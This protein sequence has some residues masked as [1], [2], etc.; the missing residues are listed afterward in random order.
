MSEKLDWLVAR[1]KAGKM[2]RRE[3]IG[4]TTAMGVSAALASAL[5]TKAA[6]AEPKK[7]GVI[8]AGLTGGES[9]NT[10][11]PALAASVMPQVA[12]AHWGEQL[13][14]LNPDG[15]VDFRIGEEVSSSADSKTWTF[16]IRQGVTFSNGQA[17]TAED[18]MATLKRHTDEASQSGALGVVKDISE[19]KA[20]GD[21]LTLTLANASADLPYLLT[22]YHLV[23]QPGGGIDNP[24]AG[25]GAG[26]YVLETFE[27][28][29]RY[30]MQKNPNYWDDRIGHADTIEILS[31]N[32]N[33]AR[34]AALQSGQV[35]MINRVDPKIA[36]LLAGA[37]GVEVRRAVG[38][39]HYVFI[40]HV[41]KPPF[42]NKDLR[43]ALK[44][45]VKRGEM[46]DKILGGLGSAG[47]DT[48]I[49]AAYPLFDDTMPQREFDAAK[50]QEF[51]KKSGH[52]GSPIILRTAA[53]AFPG[54]VDAANLFAASA[55]EAGIPLQI[56][57]DPDDGYWADV[58]NVEPFC[59]SYWGGRPTQDLMFS[60]AYLSTAE[61]NDTRF[62]NA[63]FDE[64][65]LAAR[66]ELDTVKRKSDYREMSDILREEGGLI[67]PMF[68]EF[69]AGIRSDQIA[70]WV[71]DP[72]AEMMTYRALAK[73]WLV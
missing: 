68:N 23:I 62:K 46:V 32:D 2:N 3:F 7:G 73:C 38:R 20:E 1:A 53:V 48:P 9:T 37:S 54:A 39:G 43:M 27:P 36:A 29:V 30:V 33:T 16:K 61:W 66:A 19:M 64:L 63:K 28:G 25:I 42:D 35:H 52:D 71:D 12:N 8:R 58:W 67:L 50:A 51:Y 24:T 44:L 26:P 21:K 41:D 55:K 60:T 69:V 5:Y 18:V 72:N 14:D 13:V 31:I 47:N 65:L 4:R 40:M 56:Q 57:L 17:V 49:N 34:T 10:L 45:A 22:D 6:H 15:T 70:G 59:A 11:D